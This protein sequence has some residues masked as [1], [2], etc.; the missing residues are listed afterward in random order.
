MR[1]GL[2]FAHRLCV[3]AYGYRTKTELKGSSG[4]GA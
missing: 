4:V 2:V 3:A 1:H